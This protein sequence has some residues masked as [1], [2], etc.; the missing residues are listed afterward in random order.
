[1]RRVSTSIGGRI[2]QGLLLGVAL[3]SVVTMVQCSGGDDNGGGT[4]SNPP[5]GG[6]G[7][8]AAQFA[9]VINASASDVR[10]FGLDVDGNLT[11]VGNPHARFVGDLPHHVNVDPQ[12]KFVYV[13]NHNSSF[14]SGYRI[15]QDGTL[16]PIDPRQG[17]Q[18]TGSDPSENQPHS[19]V[20][21]KTRQFLYVISGHLVTST[22]RA[23]TIDATTGALTFI[24]GQSFPIGI[25]AHNITLSPNNRFLYTASEGSGEVHA[26]SRNTTTGALTALPTIT[27]LPGALAVT[28]DPQ[29]RFLY[30]THRNELEAFQIDSNTGALTPIAPPSTFATQNEPHS[31]VIH[32]NGQ[33]LY[34]AN[35]NSSTISVFRVNPNTGALTDIQS[36][37]PATGTDPNF[38]VVHPNGR[39]LFTADNVS[40]SV[41]RFAINADGTLATPAATTQTGDGTNG[42]GTT[43]F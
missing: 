37:P 10:A 34:V 16:T 31:L 12:G 25:H 24:Q 9:Y 23:Y 41:S 27:G 30:A 43:K 4:T 26:F 38:I 3:A 29:S 39:F 32:P 28:V 6:G 7:S 18:V 8:G 13:S 19:S 1:M 36:P 20:M 42:I 22:L 33:T 5:P 11:A 15:E 17:S 35:L 14:V 21:D 2:R 40:D